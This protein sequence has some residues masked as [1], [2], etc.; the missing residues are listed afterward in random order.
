MTG[1]SHDQKR[2]I[3]QLAR[4]AYDAW[5]EREAFEAI[6]S[7]LSRSACFNA[8][9]HVEQG[10]AC[11]IQSLCECTQA[12][13]R[14]LKAHFE[15]LLGDDARA[16]RTLAGEAGND[17]RIAAHKLHAELAARDL[18]ESYAA[19]IC[20]NQFRCSLAEATTKHLWSLVF[21]IRNRRPAAAAGR[22]SQGPNPKSQMV[23]AATEEDPF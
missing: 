1:L 16:A 7:E 21:T 5:P 12:H 10:K 22:K 23:S 18:P 2:I 11:N 20:R 9:R 3:A 15:K 19:A 6:N 14:V 8:W 4:A 17:R 13:Y